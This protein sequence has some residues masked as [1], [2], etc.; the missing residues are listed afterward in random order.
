MKTTTKNFFYA[1][2]G[3]S[4]ITSCSQDSDAISNVN[5]DPTFEAFDLNSR[6][7]LP[8]DVKDAISLKGL[9]ANDYKYT[10]VGLHE[11]I[12]YPVIVTNGDMAFSKADFV[13][14][15]TINEEEQS[16]QYST[17]FL[18]DTEEFDV[19]NLYVFVGSQPAGFGLSPDA[20][21]GVR[22]AVDNWNNSFPF[23]S[24]IKFD[25]TIGT[26]PNFDNTI[27]E[28]SIAVD[29]QST[30]FG[31]FAQFPQSDNSPG[32]FL[33]ISPDANQFAGNVPDAI[34]HL[35]THELG[36][37][38]GFRHTDWDTRRSCVEAG[39]ADEEVSENDANYIPGTLPTFFY[40]ED[41][42]MNACFI[43]PEVTGELNT[44]D[45]FALRELY[46]AIPAW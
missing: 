20:V 33:F 10:E 16:R 7:E 44:F 26:N 41:S 6:L 21:Q 24:N 15:I 36:H 9:N 11:N 4:I 8:G 22:D 37:T 19:I 17:E 32:N 30:G 34:E 2:L 5:N 42:I 1:I 13:D 38:I 28:T 43:I 14:M 25:I 31:G 46:P 29:P 3:I 23:T 18:V 35:I 39:V 12:K 40:Q 27:F 45:R